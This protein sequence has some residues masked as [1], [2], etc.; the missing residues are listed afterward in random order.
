M[1]AVD[2]AKTACNC[3]TITKTP[4]RFYTTTLRTGRCFE[5][6]SAD[7]KRPKYSENKNSHSS[8]LVSDVVYIILQ[9]R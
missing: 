8:F 5:T 1:M 4:K 7:F 9:V 6:T 3:N 2:P